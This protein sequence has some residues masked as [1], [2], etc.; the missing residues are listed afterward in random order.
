MTEDVV[1]PRGLLGRTLVTWL[2]CAFALGLWS[3]A[4]PHLT[5]P[6]SPAHDLRAWGAGHGQVRLVDPGPVEGMPFA[7]MGVNQLPE[8][9]VAAASSVGCYAGQ[10]TV[11][12]GCLAEIEDRREP[13]LAYLNPLGQYHPAYYLATGWPSRF[14]GVDDA[15]TADRAVAVAL[16]SLFL[17]WAIVAARLMPRPHVAVTGV[18]VACSPQVLYFGGVLNP[19]SLEILAALAMGACSLAFFVDPDGPH[20]TA[21][22]RRALLAATVLALMRVFSPVWVACW[23]ALVLALFG[24]PALRALL[25]RANLPWLVLLVL[26]GVGNVVWTLTHLTSLAGDR[27]PYARLSFAG[28][29]H[30]SM[31]QIDQTNLAEAVG[32]FG[33]K[34]TLLRAGLVNY[35]LV[36]AVFLI[37]VC[38]VFLSRRASLAL[39]GWVAVCYLLPIVLQAV[40]WND[41]GPVWQ[42]RYTL[43]LLVLLPVSAAFLAAASDQLEGVLHL[44]LRALMPAVLL[45]VG[46]VQVAA[47]AT[48]LRRNVGGVEGGLTEGDWTPWPGSVPLL[49]AWTATVIAVWAWVVWLYW[50]AEPEQAQPERA[51]P[52]E[53]SRSRPDTRGG[54]DLATAGSPPA[55]G[56]P[57]PGQPG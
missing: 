42:A 12:A 26:A 52:S 50:R 2:A 55:P 41:N 13:L 54:E 48:L 57:P 40:Q 22:G 16:A 27:E 1:R 38:W 30:A 39:S 53:V 45:V 11:S 35:Y 36:A 25:R 18:L 4:T 47:Y 15:L 8:T 19:N 14:V 49:T 44:R 21:L 9:L 6:D 17:A 23:A 51:Q 37:G 24:M 10:P 31:Q 20:A 7:S 46:Y 33:W 29:V 28:A 56:T 32:V 43:P 34:D 5:A 3:L